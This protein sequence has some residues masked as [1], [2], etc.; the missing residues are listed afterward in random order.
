MGDSHRK[1][2]VEAWF[3]LGFQD[4]ELSLISLDDF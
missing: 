2:G 3:C 1:L 4:V